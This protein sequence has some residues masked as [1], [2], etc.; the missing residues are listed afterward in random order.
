MLR[1][2]LNINLVHILYNVYYGTYDL[3]V[4]V[5]GL[6]FESHCVPCVEVLLYSMGSSLKEKYQLVISIKA[7]QCP[8]MS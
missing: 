3:A 2:I 8:Q 1:S 6:E 5:Q 4:G 7:V